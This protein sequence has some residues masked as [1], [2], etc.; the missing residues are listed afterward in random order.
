MIPFFTLLQ[1]FTMAQKCLRRSISKSEYGA[2]GRYRK[3]GKYARRFLS[4]MGVYGKGKALSA[5]ES[6]ID[7]K[8]PLNTTYGYGGIQY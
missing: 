4:T 1:S 2:F 5:K 7:E 8:T 6:I 3:T